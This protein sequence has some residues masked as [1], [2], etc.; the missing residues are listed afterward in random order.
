M[1]NNAI[2]VVDDTL[3]SL[4]LLTDILEAEGYYVLPANSG[5]IALAAVAV[6]LPTL[7]LLDILMPGMDG[8]EVLRQ[9]KSC[10]ETHD[11][12]VIILSAV[13]ETEQRVQGLEQGAIDFISKPFQRQELLAKVKVHLELRQTRLLLEAQTTALRLSNEQLQREMAERKQA[14]ESLRKSEQGLAA[15]QRIAQ[16]G[17]WELDLSTNRLTW[18]DEMFRIFEIDQA[19]FDANYE[20]FLSS[21]HPE[22]RAEVNAA[23]SRSLASHA[24]YNITHRL[25]MPD[26]RIKHAHERCE[27]YY[28]ADGKPMRSVGTVQD[29]TE[30][31]LIETELERYR[32]HLETLVEERTAALSHAKEFAE[33]ANRAKSAFLANMSHELRTPLNA[34]LGFSELLRR[35]AAIPAAQKETLAIIHKSG[36]HLLGLLNNALEIAKI[37]AGRVSV[38]TAPFDLGATM[39]HVAGM[40]RS[41]AEDKGLQLLVNQCPRFPRYIVGDETKLRQILVNLISNAIKATKQGSITLRL[42]L[43][44]AQP[45]R[46]LMEVE[47]TGCGISPEDQTRIMAPFVQIG[48]QNEQQGTGLGLAISRRLV[49]LMGGRLS[50]TSTPGLGSTFRVELPIQPAEEEE[51]TAAGFD[52]IVHKP[53]RPEQI[54]GCMEGLWGL[55]FAR[56]VAEPAAPATRPEA[57]A[58]A[59]AAVPEPLRRSLDEA[60]VALDSERILEIID[61][62]GESA[63]DLA[64]A[65]RVQAH[66]YDYAAMLALLA[67]T[68]C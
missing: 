26:G 27:T 63:P 29:I 22:D 4:G 56:S 41:R 36:G 14:E 46:L 3:E 17:S 7:I 10:P 20:A 64:A 23:Y 35:D 1:S 60:L 25:L 28:A 68:Q 24:P 15:A 2:L 37:E 9:L 51:L 12:P 40:L 31:V 54:F 39:L 34:I 50:L 66:S 30:R 8:F 19:R 13:S 55:N 67:S 57:S 47:D 21:I 33:A 61:T 65:L 5:E 43:D 16:I 59:M 62:I 38:Q 32:Q 45:D 6:N 44:P 49:E 58:A 11:I 53:F 48:P 42:G 18:S 52:A